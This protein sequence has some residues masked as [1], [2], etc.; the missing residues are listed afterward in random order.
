MHALAIYCSLFLLI[1]LSLE[2]LCHSLT[3]SS[4]LRNGENYMH[5]KPLREIC[6]WIVKMRTN[7]Y[8]LGYLTYVQFVADQYGV[9]LTSQMR[10][11]DSACSYEWHAMKTFDCSY[12]V[13]FCRKK[14]LKKIITLK[15]LPMYRKGGGLAK[16]IY[17]V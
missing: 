12:D 16:Q 6:A 8:D 17:Y 10:R 7:R 3:V 13:R 2:N 4:A 9:V 5:Q 15:A 1:T 14:M 11:R